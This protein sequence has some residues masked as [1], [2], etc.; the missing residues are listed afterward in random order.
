MQGGAAEDRPPQ[1]FMKAP[2][3][4]ISRAAVNF[5]AEYYAIVGSVYGLC[6]SPRLWFGEVRRRLLNLGWVAH[7]LDVVLFF[8]GKMIA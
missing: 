4:P 7:V 5:S 1:I 6:K 3:D 8:C 2:T